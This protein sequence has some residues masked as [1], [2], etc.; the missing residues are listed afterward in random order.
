MERLPKCKSLVAIF[1]NDK[2]VLDG[3]H[4]IK[5]DIKKDVFFIFVLNNWELEK[6]IYLQIKMCLHLSYMLS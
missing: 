5:F 2:M 3:P 1:K 4:E 6:S